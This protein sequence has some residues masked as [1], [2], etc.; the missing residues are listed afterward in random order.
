MM[1]MMIVIKMF[2]Q[3]LGRCTCC[4]RPPAVKVRSFRSMYDAVLRDSLSATL[5][6]DI[7]DNR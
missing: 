7:D 3:L 1:M 2:R 4:E 6:V 5:N